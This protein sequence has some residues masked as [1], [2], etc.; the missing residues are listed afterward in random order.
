MKLI[1]GVK[2]I[3]S[4]VIALAAAVSTGAHAD[5]ISITGSLSLVEALTFTPSGTALQISSP[6]LFGAAFYGPDTGVAIFG[7]TNFTTEPLTP[8]Q[9]PGDLSFFP[10]TSPAATQTFQ[11]TATID[12]DNLGPDFPDQLKMT[13]TWNQLVNGG[14]AELDGVGLITESSGDIPFVTDFP[15]GGLA[16]VHGFFPTNCSLQGG[17]CD[18][19]AAMDIGRFEGG[20]ATPQGGVVPPLQPPPFTPPVPEPMS[21]FVALGTALCGL[22]GA[23]VVI[24]R[25][26]SQ[27]G[28]MVLQETNA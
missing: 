11:Y 19:L 6:G 20:D 17:N 9:Q 13:I 21:S 12:P 16:T 24:R 7:P 26:T 15:L 1:A 28:P 3:S 14:E 8:G 10:I 2:L 25:K 27:S 4:A 18:I 22:W 5:S 23:Y